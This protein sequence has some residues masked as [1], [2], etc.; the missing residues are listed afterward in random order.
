M[1]LTTQKI[2]DV[3]EEINKIPRG[4]GNETEI[5]EWLVRWAKN[6]GL[7]VTKDE[8]NN[9]LI[10]VPAT[11]GFEQSQIVVIQGH[12]DMV[13]E[14][15][16]DS[17]HD[18]TKDPIK[19]IIEGDWMHADK[20]TL[21]ADNGIA[22]AIALVIA[23]EKDCKHPPLELLFTVDE[24]RGLNG[25]KHISNNLLKGNLLINID[26]ENDEVFTIGCA[27]GRDCKITMPLE[28]LPCNAESVFEVSVGGLAG[29]HSGMDIIKNRGNANIILASILKKI[30]VQS[31]FNLI[32][33]EGGS[34]HNAIARDASACFACNLKLDQISRTTKDVEEKVKG[35]YLQEKNISTKTVEIKAKSEKMLSIEDSSK[36]LNFL[37]ALPHGVSKMSQEVIGL[38]E[39]SSNLAT[40]NTNS[41]YLSVLTS[42]RSSNDSSLDSITARIEA[43]SILVGAKCH[44]EVG[45]PAWQPDLKSNLLK[46]ASE[47][48]RNINNKEPRIEIIHAGLECG[49]IGAKY[50]EMQMISVGPN[51][52]NAHSP[53]EKLSISSLG[54]VTKFVI[55]LLKYL[56]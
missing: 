6:N 31:D 8:V 1:N 4:S 10:K 23:T 15:T 45:Y 36:V 30:S 22:L 42:Q 53:E 51:I 13:C 28:Y 39:T 47:V 5:A 37:L 20:T 14:K 52:S 50:P 19:C 12:M 26:S 16:P 38:V 41:D 55:E 32:S 43:V 18:F 49:L 27:G 46:K 2:I 3:F 7:S 34:A 17:N 24:E 29:G 35:E 56:R 33:F 48:Y 11:S 9:V 44:S 54:K 21:G 25:A 40:V